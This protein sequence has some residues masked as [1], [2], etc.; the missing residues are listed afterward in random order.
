MDLQSQQPLIDDKDIAL[1]LVKASGKEVGKLSHR[2]RDDEE[3]ILKAIPNDSIA[4]QYASNRLKNDRKFIEKAITAARQL[5]H[6][7][8]DSSHNFY[9]IIKNGLLNY[10]LQHN[11]EV[12]EAPRKVNKI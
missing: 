7:E 3:I 9:E 6:K 1:K 10:D 11:L 8:W 4:L 2:L 12:K 5:T